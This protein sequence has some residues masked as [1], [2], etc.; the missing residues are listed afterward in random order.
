MLREVFYLI[1]LKAQ[2]IGLDGS[3]HHYKSTNE[4]REPDECCGEHVFEFP[5]YAQSD[6]PENDEKHVGE[7][8]QERVD[9]RHGHSANGRIASD[10]FEVLAMRSCQEDDRACEK[11]LD[12]VIVKV[13]RSGS[14]IPD[15]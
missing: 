13:R 8:A 12:C 15:G 1:Q 14:W 10:V 7:T 6:G 9:H 5:V 4:N 3:T 2:L 11:G